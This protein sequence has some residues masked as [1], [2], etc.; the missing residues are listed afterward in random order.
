MLLRLDAR[1]SHIEVTSDVRGDGDFKAIAQVA[2]LNVSDTDV[3]QCQ[4]CFTPGRVLSYRHA[5]TYPD[6][7]GLSLWL[8]LHS[9]A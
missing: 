6:L 8:V 4:F 2:I 7:K 1:P 3:R 5:G 9:Y